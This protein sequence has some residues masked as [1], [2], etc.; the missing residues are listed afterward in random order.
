MGL[1]KRVRKFAQVGIPCSF[2]FVLIDKGN[3]T[4]SLA[5]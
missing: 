5:R 3:L 4:N 2:N 1:A